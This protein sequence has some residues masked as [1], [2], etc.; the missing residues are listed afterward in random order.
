MQPV[1]V[2]SS[3]RS[4][5][6]CSGVTT[7]DGSASEDPATP[8]DGEFTVTLSAV[9]ST[10]TT[11]NYTLTGTATNGTDYQT[12]GASVTFAAGTATATLTVTPIDNS[13]VG[14]SKTVTVTV[15]H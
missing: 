9:S 2:E 5:A 12:L 3:L 7:S 4:S 10:P 13:V 8:D 1:I 6:I 11:V 14:G 15:P